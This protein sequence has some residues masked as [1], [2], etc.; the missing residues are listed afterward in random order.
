[1]DNIDI[2]PD[3]DNVSYTEPVYNYRGKN[4]RVND[5]GDIVKR[6]S[7]ENAIL[8]TLENSH[9]LEKYERKL[10]RTLRGSNYEFN[11]R[12]DVMLNYISKD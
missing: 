6:V 8:A 1:M 2:K 9:P 10:F 5:V 4:I 7:R 3:E 12:W 11:R